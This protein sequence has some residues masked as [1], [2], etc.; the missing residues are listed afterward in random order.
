MHYFMLDEGTVAALTKNNNK[1]AICTLNGAISFHGAIRRKKDGSFFINV[2]LPIC[3][4]L[5][6]KSGAKVFASFSIDNTKYQFE[7]PEE[8]KEILDQDEEAGRIF[9]AL[10]EGNQRSLIYLVSQVKST[11]KKIERGLK[12]AERLKSGVTSPKL[13]LK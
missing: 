2:A 13:I 12:I 3:K 7:M 5:K 4:Q 6:I 8:F 1:R 11:H 10:T 9:H